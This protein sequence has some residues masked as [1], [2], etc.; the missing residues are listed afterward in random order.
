[1]NKNKLYNKDVISCNYELNRIYFNLNKG[2]YTY[3]SSQSLGVENTFTLNSFEGQSFA[4]YGYDDLH[5]LFHNNYYISQVGSKIVFEHYYE[6][7]DD[8]LPPI[9]MDYSTQV[10]LKNCDVLRTSTNIDVDLG[11]CEITQEDLD[12]IEKNEVEL[13]YYY[14]C[15]YKAYSKIYLSKLD[16]ANPVFEIK[17]S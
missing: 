12:Y 15:G 10:P 14:L 2:I 5:P 11:Y 13:I 16:E 7:V 3:D 9:F 8:S 17:N 1:M 6:G 4:Y